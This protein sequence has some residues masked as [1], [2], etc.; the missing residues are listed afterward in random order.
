MPPLSMFLGGSHDIPLRLTP[1]FAVVINTGCKPNIVFIQFV[2][3]PLTHTCAHTRRHKFKSKL[4]KARLVSHVYICI[5]FS[6]VCV[7]VRVRV[8]GSLARL[9]A[10][11][12]HM[13]P[14]S[15]RVSTPHRHTCSPSARGH[16]RAC[17]HT[18]THTLPHSKRKAHTHA[19]APCD[20]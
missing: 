2:C 14:L 4:K 16:T 3:H 8:G 10:C 18:H 20:L 5:D 11:S 1:I 7:C 15:G 13:C 17:T 6:C 9:S 12:A 19:P